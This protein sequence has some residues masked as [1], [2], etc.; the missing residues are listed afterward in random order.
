[1]QAALTVLNVHVSIS[2]AKL[3]HI[4][5][6]HNSHAIQTEKRV[7]VSVAMFQSFCFVLIAQFHSI[8]IS[9]SLIPVAAAALSERQ[10][11]L[12]YSLGTIFADIIHSLLMSIT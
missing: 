9:L 3:I 6:C 11:F 4:N 2:Q 5:M 7:F 8:P 10:A 12:C 1:M